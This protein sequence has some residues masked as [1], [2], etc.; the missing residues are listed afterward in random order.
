MARILLVHLRKTTAEICMPHLG[1]A[2]LATVLRQAGHTSVVFDEVLHEPGQLPSLAQVI[3]DTRPDV[4]GFTSYTATRDRLYD[5]L[6]QVRRD[7]N[8]PLLVGGPHAT[9]FTDDLVATGLPD[10]VVQGEAEGFITDVVQRAQRLPQPEV[11]PTTPPDVTQLPWPVYDDFIGHERIDTYPLLTSRGCPYK[12]NFCGVHK[13]ASHRWR[14]RGP[15]DCVAEL[16]ANLPKLPRVHAIRISD[17]C[18]TG[19][20]ERFKEFLRLFIEMDL[21]LP[22]GVDNLR[23]DLLDAEL[24]DLLKAAGCGMLCFGV[25]SG[26]PEVFAG[27]NKGETHEQI[28]HAAALTKAAGLQLALCFVIGLPGDNSQRHEDS[29]RFARELNPTLVFWN[30]A[31]PFPGTEM[32]SWF[33]EQGAQLDPPRTYTSYDTHSLVCPEPTVSTSDFTKWQRRRAYFQAVVETDQYSFNRHAPWHLLTGAIRYRLAGPALHSFG[34][35]AARVLR[36][37]GGA[38]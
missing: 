23:A 32:H 11:V 4:I 5:L 37:V 27:V 22:L 14:A 20:P 30:L 6:A 8:L 35:R 17:D 24:V 21:K 36:R 9:L 38:Q 13:V 10:Y 3:V 25:E 1:L 19:K 26:N 15:Q 29:I 2:S 31:H 16:A 18:P 7:T 28:R 33:V 34:R 12:C